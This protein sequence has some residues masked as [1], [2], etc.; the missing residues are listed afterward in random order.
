MNS[1][2]GTLLRPLRAVGDMD[3]LLLCRQLTLI[4]LILHAPW[5]WYLTIPLQAL[6]ILG[7]VYRP[8]ARQPDFWLLAAA[9]LASA[10]IL[11]WYY[12]DNHKYLLCYWVIALWIVHMTPAGDRANILAHN[13]RWLV[14]LTMLFATVWKVI[15]PPFWDGTV[16]QY[17]LLT[18]SR[19]E[20]VARWIG[21]ASQS[22][23][24]LNRDL[25]QE[26]QTGHL[27]GREI[28]AVQLSTA[29]RI[30]LVAQSI[31]WWT[32]LIEGAIGVAFCLPL[33]RLTAARHW[34]LLIFAATTYLVAPVK[35][36]GW[37][38]MILGIAQCNK[39]DFRYRLAYFIVFLLIHF[40]ILPFGEIVDIAL[41]R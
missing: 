31:T 39:S 36:F 37:L 21:G 34:L 16:F 22:T 28:A 38:L 27:H 26:L 10:T 32:I 18:D 8:V 2:I 30:G 14:G 20:Y 19:F 11:N 4:L 3:S 33:R 15:E 1:G 17:L 25:I 7:L 23:L 41:L 6:C 13:A 35:G 24:A 5:I 40:Y 9:L 12:L 29:A